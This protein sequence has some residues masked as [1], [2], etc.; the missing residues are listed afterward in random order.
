[1][2]KLLLFGAA[3][4]ACWAQMP[5][6]MAAPAGK[7]VELLPGLG[8]WKHPI[9]TRNV[10]AQKFF[11]QGLALLYGFNRPEALRSFRKALELDPRAAMAQWGVAMALGP[12]INMDEDP[13]V[14]IPESCDAAASTPLGTAVSRKIRS[15]QT[16][17]DAEPRPGISTFH[18]TFFVSLHSIGGSAVFDTPLAYGPRHCGQYLSAV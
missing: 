15:P 18:L 7:P 10:Q 13:D 14:H 5:H 3:A 1:M 8:A 2:K 11:D 12:Y 6:P 4:C 17:G 9:A 16:T